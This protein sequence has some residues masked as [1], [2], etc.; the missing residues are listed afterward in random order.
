MVFQGLFQ[1][2]H[3]VV[4][5]QLK[6]IPDNEQDQKN[7]AREAHI[8]HVASSALL[9]SGHQA[10]LVRF[11]GACASP[12]HWCLVYENMPEGSAKKVLLD[13][14]KYKSDQPYDVSVILQMALDVARGLSYLHSKKIVH[15][16]VACRNLLIFDEK[17][18]W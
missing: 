12:P 18:L 14:N 17:R 16:D 7:F 11:Y 5:K 15:R 2:R 13:E 6:S 8:S 4:I 1:E 10:N 9:K 3:P